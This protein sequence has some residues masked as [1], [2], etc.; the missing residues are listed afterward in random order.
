[1]LTKE[2]DEKWSKKLTPHSSKS[3]FRI[4][5]FTCFKPLYRLGLVCNDAGFIGRCLATF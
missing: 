4:D 5:C 1:V 2:I 3:V